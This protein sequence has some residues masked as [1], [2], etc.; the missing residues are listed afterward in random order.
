MKN[1]GEDCDDK[2]SSYADKKAF[3]VYIKSINAGGWVETGLRPWIMEGS[4]LLF[5]VAGGKAISFQAS[6]IWFIRR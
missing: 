1:N 5:D 4:N 2:E 6:V 3:A